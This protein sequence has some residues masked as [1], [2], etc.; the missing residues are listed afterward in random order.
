[1]YHSFVV[2]SEAADGAGTLTVD[3]LARAGGTTVRNVRALQTNGL[4]PGPRVEGRT[5]YY[6]ADHLLRLSAVL[7]LQSEGFS[8]AALR[9]LLRAW[10]T[11]MTLEE[12]LGLPRL[13]GRSSDGDEQ[14]PDPFEGFRGHAGRGRR[15]RLFVVPTTIIGNDD[16]SAGES[17]STAKAAS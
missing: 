15:G 8:L 2:N 17:L 6:G 14:G 1:M 11:G 4:V 9:T 12:V 13:S 3:E 5:G 10:E 7:R 16:T